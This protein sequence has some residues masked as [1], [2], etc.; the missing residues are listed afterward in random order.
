MP[1]AFEREESKRI[2]VPS[3]RKGPTTTGV[4]DVITTGRECT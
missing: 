3:I 4:V 2:T 1:T